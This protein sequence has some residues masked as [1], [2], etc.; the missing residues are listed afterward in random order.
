EK[1]TIIESFVY[2]SS[3]N[4]GDIVRAC[5]GM[6]KC[7]MGNHTS[8]RLPQ[9]T[10]YLQFWLISRCFL[11]CIVVSCQTSIEMKSSADTDIFHDL[12]TCLL[13]VHNLTVS[14]WLHVNRT[15]TR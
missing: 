14:G 9:G 10:P 1:A 4:H 2:I 12:Q 15:N 7:I 13:A 3:F 11:C 5:W 6:W 8:L